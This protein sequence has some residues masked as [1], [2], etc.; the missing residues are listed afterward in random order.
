M[1]NQIEQSLLE[2]ASRYLPKTGMA[3]AIG[4]ARL[5]GSKLTAYVQHG[6]T[7]IDHNLAEQAIRPTKLGMKNGLFIGHPSARKR[8]AMIDTILECCRRHK[9][10]PLAYLNDM[11]RLLPG[12]TNHE[13][14]QG[15]IEPP[16]LDPESQG[17]IVKPCPTRAR[18]DAYVPTPSVLEAGIYQTR[19]RYPESVWQ[20]RVQSTEH[21]LKYRRIHTYSQHKNSLSNS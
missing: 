17:L 10:E 21:P 14:C 5:Q 12:M 11:L 13:G 19:H 9:V 18:T 2:D 1:F 15:Q 8:A 3:D 20:G 7:R 4:Y 16:S 6:Q